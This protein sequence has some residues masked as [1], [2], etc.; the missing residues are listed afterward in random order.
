MV[1]IPAKRDEQLIN[2]ILA[3][4]RLGKLR[5]KVKGFVGFENGNQ[6]LYLSERFIKSRWHLRDVTGM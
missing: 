6:I 4:L 1:H 3:R 2:E 5:R